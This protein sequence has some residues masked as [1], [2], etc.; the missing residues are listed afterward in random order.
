MFY[1]CKCFLTN[2]YFVSKYKLH[3][4]YGN[5]S[6]TDFWTQFGDQLAANGC[7]SEAKRAEVLTQLKTEFDRRSRLDAEA[8]KRI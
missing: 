8:V 7:D 4:K 5:T 6:D 3:V 1:R 2:N